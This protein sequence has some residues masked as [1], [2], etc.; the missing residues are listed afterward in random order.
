[1]NTV[2]VNGSTVS[3]IDPATINGAN[4]ISADLANETTYTNVGFNFTDEIKD[5][6]WYLDN[7]IA[8]IREGNL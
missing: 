3:S 2:T 4:I 1:M 7:G 6:I 5:Y 8:K